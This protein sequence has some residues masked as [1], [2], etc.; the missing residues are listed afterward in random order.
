MK[1]AYE[2][3]MERLEQETPSATLSDEQKSALAEIDA[4]FRAKI[5]EKEVF[6]NGEIL[7]SQRSGD[8]V[9]VEEL[10]D[11]LRREIRRLEADCEET[12]DKVRAT[13]A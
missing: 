3:A 10:R 5:A 6:L 8:F 4:K 9:A 11:Q 12:K 7:K 2:L 13:K 1:S